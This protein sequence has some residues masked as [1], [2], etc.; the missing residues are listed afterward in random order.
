MGRE[1]AGK[2][3]GWVK[4][5]RRGEEVTVQYP[6]RG[7]TREN[8]LTQEREEISRLL[9]LGH[10]LANQHHNIRSVTV[11]Q[12]VEFVLSRVLHAEAAQ[13]EPSR[14]PVVKEAAAPLPP[15]TLAKTHKRGLPESD[16]LKMPLYD[17][18]V[19]ATNK[20]TRPGDFFYLVQQAAAKPIVLRELIQK[21]IAT[22]RPPSSMKDHEMV[23]RVR[24][25]DAYTRLGYLRQA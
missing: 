6:Q 9:S 15:R 16:I 5:L 10:L 17:A 4:S 19:V 8:A 11:E 18:V 3:V 1:A 7:L 20:S 23:I 21:L 13:P 22:Y 25:K 24:T 12:I 14:V 2:P